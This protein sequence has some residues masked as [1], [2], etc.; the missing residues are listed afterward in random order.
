MKLNNEAADFYLSILNIIS[1]KVSGKFGYAVARNIRALKDS[2]S[3]YTDIKNKL[4][5]EYGEQS[6][7]SIELRV[8]S[9]NFKKYQEEIKEYNVIEHDVDIMQIEPEEVYKSSLTADVISNIM[10]MIKEVND[11]G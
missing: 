11:N 3:E 6:N 8:D 9:P 5:T 4:I 1:S 7:N 10:F 2:L